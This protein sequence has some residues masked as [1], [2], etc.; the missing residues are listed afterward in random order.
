MDEFY[1]NSVKII[2]HAPFVRSHS[3]YPLYFGLMNGKT[4]NNSHFLWNQLQED[5]VYI[6]LPSNKIQAD[7]CIWIKYEVSL[8]VRNFYPKFRKKSLCG[9]LCVCANG[10]FCC[11]IEA[12]FTYSCQKAAFIL[13]LHIENIHGIRKFQMVTEI[14]F[15]RLWVFVARIGNQYRSYSF[16]LVFRCYSHWVGNMLRVYVS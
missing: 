11:T 10:C 12:I 15:N 7:K 13:G 2:I 9:F 5:N 3:N 8:N 16:A 1:S 14:G 6:H 4:A